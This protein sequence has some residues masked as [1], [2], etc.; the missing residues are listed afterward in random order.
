[1]G[2]TDWLMWLVFM[3]L[4]LRSFLHFFKLDKAM[5]D[6]GRYFGINFMAMFSLL[7]FPWAIRQAER[8]Y[9][10]EQKNNR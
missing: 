1:M 9:V 4:S 5:K 7:L 6:E 10:R 8:D 2:E 3:G